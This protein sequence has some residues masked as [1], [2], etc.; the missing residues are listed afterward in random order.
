MMLKAVLSIAAALVISAASAPAHSVIVSDYY[1]G[2]NNHGYGDVIGNVND[3]QI[4]FMDVNI[5]GTVLTVSIDTTFAGKGSAGLY[6][7]LTNGA[8]GIGYGD[9]FL[10]NNLA[11]TNSIQT[12]TDDSSSGTVWSHGFSLADRFSESNGAG[13]LFSLNANNNAD[14]IQMSDEFLHSGFFRNNHEV[15]VDRNSATV[16]ALGNIGSWSTTA[17][18]VDFA[19]DLA[20]TGLLNGDELAMRWGFTCANDVIEGAVKVPEVPVPAA[21]WLFGS[22]LLGLAAVAR[23]KR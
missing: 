20:G 8:T 3:F 21:V 17:T 2:G 1:I 6:S 11:P 13:T 19:I 22:G 4:N 23:R 10:S 7:G 12:E 15:A 14:N 18:T 16:S 9:L 5:S